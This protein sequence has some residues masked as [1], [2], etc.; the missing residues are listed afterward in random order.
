MTM[1]DDSQTNQAAVQA[2]DDSGNTVDER[3][4]S[5]DAA[6]EIL[7]RL[8]DEGFDGDDEKFAIALGRPFEEVVGF[9]TGAA[10]VDDDVVMKARG[11]A[12]RRNIQID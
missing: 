2:G 12:S 9:L 4:T 3:G 11:I 6:R 10:T 7:R 5:E 8:R 1:K